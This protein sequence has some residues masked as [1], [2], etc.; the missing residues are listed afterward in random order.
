MRFNNETKYYIQQ[1]LYSMAALMISGTVLQTFLLESGID[2][3][4]VSFYTSFMQ[5]MQMAVMILCSRRLENLK[6]IILATA[7]VQIMQTAILAA[8]LALCYVNNITITAKY[9]FVFA[10]G[11]FT[12]IGA[13]IYNVVCYKI[14]YHIMKMNRYGIVMG[15]TGIVTGI[16]GILFSTVLTVFLNKYSYFNVMSAFLLSGIAALLAAV[17]ITLSYRDN[18][19]GNTCNDE[20]EKINL[21]AYSPFLILFVPNLLRGFVIGIFNLMVTVGYHY[22]VLDTVSSGYLLIITNVTM[23]IGCA[24]YSLMARHNIDRWIIFVSSMGICIIMPLI[25]AGKSTANFLTMYGIGYFILNLINYSVPVA[26]T[27][28]VDY[29]IIGQY[30][31]WRMMLNTLGSA[32]SGIMCIPMLEIFGGTPAFAI[33]GVMQLLSGGAYFLCMK[34]VKKV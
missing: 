4:A 23:I 17:A 31:A 33:I 3:G 10:V 18:G 1:G 9:Y 6:N 34:K 13:G 25:L 11:I 12:N 24:A 30:T 14:P 2:A 27:K 20:R 16:I 29:K 26:V 15:I 7:I 21:F 28:I 32:L 19:F 22:A 5:V 8:L